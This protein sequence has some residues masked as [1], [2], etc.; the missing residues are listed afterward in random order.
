MAWYELRLTG[1]LGGPASENQDL[2]EAFRTVFPSDPPATPGPEGW[3]ELF[4]WPTGF[5]LPGYKPTRWIS[6][7][8]D[9]P[10]QVSKQAM[11]G[12]AVV[13]LLTFQVEMFATFPGTLF[14]NKDHMLKEVAWFYNY[15]N[16]A[17]Y[18][19]LKRKVN[20]LNELLERSGRLIGR[21]DFRD[22]KWYCGN[23]G[24]D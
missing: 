12:F 13:T 1:T 4:G 14:I 6:A 20:Q 24:G 16:L 5:L 23:G 2:I 8:D 17:W 21:V 19:D 10:S 9:V 7:A 11:G 18:T 22:W 15:C 3:N